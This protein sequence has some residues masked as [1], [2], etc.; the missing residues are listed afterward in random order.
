M[1]RHSTRAFVASLLLALPL[2]VTAAAE[3][4]TQVPVGSRHYAASPLPDRI[5]ASP[6]ADPSHGFAVAWRTDG[7]V[8]APLLEIARAGDSPAIEGIRAL[9]ATT[10]A[11]QTENGLSHHHRVD[12]DGLQPDTAYIYR[13]Q[14]LSLIHI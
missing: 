2:L 11:L 6:S 3:P 5:V 7:S 12:I 1:R 4:N 9:R 13:V 8:Q 14:G 10:Q